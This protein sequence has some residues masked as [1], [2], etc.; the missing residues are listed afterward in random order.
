MK[1]LFTSSTTIFKK[2]LTITLIVICLFQ[3]NF[4]QDIINSL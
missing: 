2:V 1:N 4:S 3:Q